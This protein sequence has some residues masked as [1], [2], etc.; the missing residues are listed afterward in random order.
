MHSPRLITGFTA[1]LVAA[2]GG[3]GDSG[4]GGKYTSVENDALTMEFSGGKVAMNAAGMG[5]SSGTYTVEGEKV[6]VTVEGQSHTF[7]RDGN[8]I[9]DQ[10]AVFGKLCKGGKGGEASN[11]S[12]REEPTTTGTWVATHPEGE[13]RI[14]F[15]GDNAMTMTMTP[16][17]GAGAQ[18]ESADGTFR[19]EGSD[20]HL[21]FTDGMP[22]VLNFVN[23]GYETTSLGFPLRFVRQ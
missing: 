18:A 20:V 12:T 22:M 9:A 13:F 23:D 21:S 16:A 14:E 2:C 8:C 11:V 4:V 6:I 17:A 3:G 10:L 7:L 5:S 15:K 1:F 19:V